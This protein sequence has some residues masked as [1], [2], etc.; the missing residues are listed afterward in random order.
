[1]CSVRLWIAH[2]GLSKILSWTR[3]GI[4]YKSKPLSVGESHGCLPSEHR[5]PPCP[6]RP[7]GI[8]SSRSPRSNSAGPTVHQVP[9]AL[10]CSR[11]TQPCPPLTPPLII[12]VYLW[13][14]CTGASLNVSRG[15]SS[16]PSVT[17]ERCSGDESGVSPQY[18]GQQVAQF[19]VLYFTG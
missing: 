5:T 14:T 9:F 15:W 17:L 16:T 19:S 18:P 2:M 6:L 13:C 10:H 3:A 7:P 8:L 12:S 4:R 11:P 1:M